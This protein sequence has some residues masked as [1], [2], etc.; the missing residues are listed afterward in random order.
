MKKIVLFARVSTNIQDYERQINE[1]TALAEQNNWIISAT[2]CEKISGAKKNTE[3]KELSKMIDYVSSNNIDMVV[4]TELSRLGRDTLQVLEVIE[5]FNKL[6][7]HD[8]QIDDPGSTAI[9]MTELKSFSKTKCLCIKANGFC[10]VL[11]RN[12]NM[13][14]TSNHVILPPQ[15]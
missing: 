14:D 10:H 15:S 13:S 6:A 9:R 7:G 3:R 5:Q 8:I 11:Y 4:V 12:G 1:L 2:F